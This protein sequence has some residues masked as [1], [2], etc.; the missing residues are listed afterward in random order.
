MCRRIHI[1]CISLILCYFIIFYFLRLLCRSYVR[2]SEIVMASPTSAHFKTRRKCHNVLN[3]D[4]INL[5][6][7]LFLSKLRRNWMQSNT[8]KIKKVFLVQYAKMCECFVLFI[9]WGRLCSLKLTDL[10]FS[11]SA[12]ILVYAPV[13]GC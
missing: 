2:I 1:L 4:K 13:L 8:L 5:I 12:H 7:I 10:N 6:K 9:Y 11:N 3:T